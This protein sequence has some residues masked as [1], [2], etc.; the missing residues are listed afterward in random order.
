M[1]PALGIV[2]CFALITP[3]CAWGA[4]H[5]W[6]PMMQETLEMAERGEARAAAE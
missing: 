5:F 6:M 1:N 3:V 4:W 2:L